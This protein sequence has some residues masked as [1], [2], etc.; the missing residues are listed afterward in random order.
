[1]INCYRQGIFCR[2]K[3][4][5]HPTVV[6]SIRHPRRKLA[7]KRFSFFFFIEI[8][9]SIFIYAHTDERYFVTF[10][11]LS[12]PVSIFEWRFQPQK[13]NR[14][15]FDETSSTLQF[16]SSVPMFQSMFFLEVETF[17]AESSWIA[18]P[19]KADMFPAH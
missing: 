1:M 3:S 16:S 14:F 9:K 12:L 15:I 10:F 11:L 7:N 8:V 6:M 19:V 18:F 5:R 13:F 2:Q 4:I 17:F